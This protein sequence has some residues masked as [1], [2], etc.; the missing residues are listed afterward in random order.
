M[1]LGFASHAGGRS[2]LRPYHRMLRSRS[3]LERQRSMISDEASA[4]GRGL[5]AAAAAG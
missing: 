3:E 4:G 1:A 5:G 2:G